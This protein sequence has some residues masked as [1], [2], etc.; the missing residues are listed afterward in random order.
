VEVLSSKKF[1]VP[2]EYVTSPRSVFLSF[3][4]VDTRSDFW[5]W[6]II[7]VVTLIVVM[8]IGYY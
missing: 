7:V 6:K 8:G 1:G 3:F 5:G 4:S 2:P